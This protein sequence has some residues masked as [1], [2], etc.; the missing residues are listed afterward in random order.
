[1]YTT[2][3]IVK[4]AKF[5]I[6]AKLTQFLLRVEIFVL[7]SSSLHHIHFHN[8]KLEFLILL[9]FL[10]FFREDSFILHKF[11]LDLAKKSC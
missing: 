8:L 3:S 4:L 10:K 7:I 6:L 9:D 1:M 2:N 5:H 11:F